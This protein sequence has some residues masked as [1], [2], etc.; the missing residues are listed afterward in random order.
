MSIPAYLSK[1]QA[2]L[3]IAL[4]EMGWEQNPSADISNQRYQV[5]RVPDGEQDP[6]SLRKGNWYLFIEYTGAAIPS[7]ESATLV[8]RDPKKHPEPTWKLSN[9][10]N[11]WTFATNSVYPSG[12]DALI[13]GNRRQIILTVAADPATP[14][15]LIEEHR[16]ARRTV[17]NKRHELVT[18]GL[19]VTDP[20]EFSE[21]THALSRAVEGLD[22]ANGM[23]DL[24]ELVEKASSL[25]QELAELIDTPAL[26]QRRNEVAEYRKLKADPRS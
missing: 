20:R 19:P 21:R 1:S 17:E 5:S 15:W 9:G 10:V 4:Y 13:G 8:L 24:G 11:R 7:I 25:I 12:I 2:S 16:Y 3:L 26:E 23:T 14:V 22:R 18:A 6:F